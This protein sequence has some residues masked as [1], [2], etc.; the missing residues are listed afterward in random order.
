MLPMV[1]MMCGAVCVDVFISV[2]GVNEV[3]D[4]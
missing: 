3:N 2:Y 1:M 4:A